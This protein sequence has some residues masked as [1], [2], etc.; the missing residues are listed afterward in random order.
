MKNKNSRKKENKKCT[1]SMH[2]FMVYG[3]WRRRRQSANEK[4]NL[5]F[6]W[7]AN[8]NVWCSVFN[9]MQISLTKYWKFDLSFFFSFPTVHPKPK[10]NSI[11]SEH[12]FTHKFSISKYAK[13]DRIGGKLMRRNNAND[14]QIGTH[15]DF[16]QVQRRDCGEE[17]L[18]WK[19]SIRTPISMRSN[20]FCHAVF[21]VIGFF[22]WE[23]WLRVQ[24]IVWMNWTCSFVLNNSLNFR[25]RILQRLIQLCF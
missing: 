21:D 7:N 4:I 8:A 11:A 6:N 9:S 12:W 20:F 15:F 19:H 5:N 14:G 3:E 13:P 23:F 22:C 16:V 24:Y 2:A 10:Y 25:N 1:N 18:I 17:K